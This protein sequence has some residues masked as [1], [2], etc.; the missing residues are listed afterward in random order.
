M[1]GMLADRNLH[2]L[3]TQ[4]RQATNTFEI[5]HLADHIEGD[6]SLTKAALKE[7]VRR[8]RS[9]IAAERVTERAAGGRTIHSAS[10]TDLAT[11]S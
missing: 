9:A 1:R 11:G 4:A 5:R 7:I 3:I 6:G 10:S 2:N 8:A